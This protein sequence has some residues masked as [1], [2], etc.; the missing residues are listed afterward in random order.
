MKAITV[1]PEWAALVAARLKP[2]ENRGP[3]SPRWLGRAIGQRVAVHAGKHVGGR[4]GLPAWEEAQDSLWWTGLPAGW[5]IELRHERSEPRIRWRRVPDDDPGQWQSAPLARGAIVCT[6]V[7]GRPHRP[8]G[9]P[10]ENDDPTTW[11]WPLLDVQPLAVPVPCRGAQGLWTT[12]ETL[13]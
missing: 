4:P 1:W 11:C 10:W 13:P 2:L 5:E 7:L 9:K 3:E 8:S 12:W 6:A